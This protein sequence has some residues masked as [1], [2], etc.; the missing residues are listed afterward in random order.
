MIASFS[1]FKV[2]NV[3][4]AVK[5]PNNSF[6]PFTIPSTVTFDDLCIK[7]SEKLNRFPG[8]LQLRYRLDS[9]K[10]KTGPTSIQTP[11]ELRLFIERM[12]QLIVPQRLPSGRISARALKP[13]RVLFEDA[14]EEP[15]ER[16]DGGSKPAGKQVS[17]FKL[18]AHSSY[19]SLFQ[20]RSCK[21]E[22][23]SENGT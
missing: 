17:S 11:D 13:V 16:E 18:R 7:V 4:C 14:T 23:W 19:Y 21:E 20:E 22:H 5:C 10:P 15:V 1:S 2:F 9:D 12:K 8:L 6:S 3:D